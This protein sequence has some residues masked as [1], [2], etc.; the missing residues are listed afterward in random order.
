MA[1][2]KI[3]NALG[4]IV[5]KKQLFAANE[6]SINLSSFAAGV[7]SVEL[8]DKDHIARRKLIKQ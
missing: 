8:S 5:F 4:E 1:D 6:N 3:F 7:Y 2:L